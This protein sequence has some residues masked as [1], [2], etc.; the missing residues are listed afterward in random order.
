M[1]LKMKFELRVPQ[2]PKNGCEII[3]VDGPRDGQK[4]TCESLGHGSG[5]HSEAEQFWV[6]TKGGELGSRFMGISPGYL[7]A[8]QDQAIFHSDGTVSGIGPAQ[9]HVYEVIRRVEDDGVLRIT[10][11]YEGTKDG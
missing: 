6:L 3:F 10:C 2:L 9:A 4:L 1:P 5:G 8:L 7:N 11:Q